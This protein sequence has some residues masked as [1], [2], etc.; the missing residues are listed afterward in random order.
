MDK[1]GQPIDSVSLNRWF[2]M[3]YPCESELTPDDVIII[4]IYPR[5]LIEMFQN[6]KTVYYGSP[7]F[8][9]KDV[10]GCRI[11]FYATAPITGIVAIARVVKRLL[12]TPSQLYEQLGGKGVFSLEQ[13]GEPDTIKQAIVFDGL[14]P[15]TSSIERQQ[16]I[17]LGI[18][19][20]HP[21]SSHTLP[22]E[23]FNRVMA[24]VGVYV[25]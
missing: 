1:D 12:G 10:T 11:I 19:N 16:A 6:G 2:H 18:F 5:F 7:S 15:L 17:N 22:M 25:P 21:Q 23:S 14:I 4:P 20:R 13:I 24:Q 9:N 3:A 8:T